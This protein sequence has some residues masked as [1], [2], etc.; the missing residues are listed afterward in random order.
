MQINNMHLAKTCQGEQF[1]EGRGQ[2]ESIAL[3]KI[4]IVCNAQQ[5]QR[6]APLLHQD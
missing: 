6:R 1:T 3:H 4:A 5:Y 2:E